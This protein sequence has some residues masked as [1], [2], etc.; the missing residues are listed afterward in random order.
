MKRWDGL[1]EEYLH[2]C[3]VAGLSMETIKSRGSELGRWG[4]WMKRRR[5]KPT[6]EKIPT[7][8]IVEYIR[9]RSVY[10]AKASVAGVVSCLRCMGRFLVKKQVWQSNPLRW[11]R[12]P[13][14]DPRA[15]LPKR[16]GKEHL[17]ALWKEAA[18]SREEYMRHLRLAVLAVL[19]STGLRRGELARLDVSGWNRDEGVLTVDGRKSGRER[20]VP[21]AEGVARV[22]EAYLPQR[23]NLLE[24][25]GHGETKALFLT[26]RGARLT[27]LKVSSHVHSVARK[28]GVPLV[29]IHQFRHTCASD[30]I[31]AG[32]SLPEVQDILG[33]AAIETTMRYLSISDPER[34]KAMEKH[35]LEG[36]LVSPAGK[37]GG[38]ERAE[39]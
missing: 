27:G 13:R 10:H 37:G 6:L 23:H 32:V 12:G 8:Q 35:P 36:V 9:S 2:E 31:E 38:N 21:V 15:R 20:R 7:E 11:I 25:V 39:A 14:M 24:R 30:L 22:I 17:L 29:S 1:V 33:H 28:A 5:P 4:G 3:E 19:Y 16:L 34:R 26:R 18:G